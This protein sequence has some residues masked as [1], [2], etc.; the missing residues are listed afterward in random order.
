MNIV[1]E[2]PHKPKARVLGH[3]CT[4]DDDS[5][6]YL[7][8]RKHGQIYRAGK[9]SISDA[10][11]EGKAGWALDEALLYSLR[12]RG[13]SRVGIRVE[14]TGDLYL[15]SLADFFDRLKSTS[16]ERNFY[17]KVDRRRMLRM[18][19]FT[20]EKGAVAFNADKIAA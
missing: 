15:A 4:L 1:K 10:M 3:F 13:I 14:D 20:V 6:I 2:T 18:E 19:H 16:D 9:A 17:G 8:R 7:A 5:V 12:A 11:A